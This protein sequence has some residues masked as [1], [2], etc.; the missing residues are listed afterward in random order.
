VVVLIVVLAVVLAVVLGAIALNQAVE[1]RRLK[2]EQSPAAQREEWRRVQ[3]QG[4]VVARFLKAT[5]MH[6]AREVERLLD[7]YWAGQ[8]VLRT[9]AA[10]RRAGEDSQDLVEA[11]EMLLQAE[12]AEED[13]ARLNEAARQEDENW[14]LS[15]HGLAP[16]PLQS[17]PAPMRAAVAM[18]PP[19]PY[20]SLRRVGWVKAE[21]AVRYR[22]QAQRAI[23]RVIYRYNIGQ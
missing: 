10:L 2:Q 15:E 11:A 17:V 9:P 6:S 19:S 16:R 13:Q 4:L 21:S 20:L 3:S 18:L 1:T 7:I 5:P 8:L 14:R 22:A 23:S 12:R